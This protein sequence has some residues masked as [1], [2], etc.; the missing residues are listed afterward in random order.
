MWGAPP[1]QCQCPVEVENVSRTPES[2]ARSERQR[3]PPWLRVRFG[4]DRVSQETKALVRRHA[5]HTVCEEAA[6]PN[7]GECW[8]RR[9]A[10]V[11]ILGSVC[12]RACSFCNV[13]TGAPFAPDPDEPRRLAEAVLELGLRHVVITSVNRDDL[14]DGGAGQFARC[15]EEIHA[16]A[17]RVTV[18][19]LTPDFRRKEGAL[20]V[21]VDA[22]PDVFNHNLET[23]P[24][25]YRAVRPGAD[26]AH[27]VRLLQRVKEL[28]PGA[29][30]KSGIMLGLGEEHREVL[31]LMDDLR[32]ADV[33]FLTMGQ[34]LRPTPRHRMVDRY[35][36][37]AEFDDYREHAEAK[38]FLLVSSTPL[39]RSSY[40]A[41]ADFERLRRARSGTVS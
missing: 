32:A 11:M 5:L 39:T 13:E 1:L 21:V 30:T 40:H 35:V 14:L 6:C 22:R 16:R 36:P 9:H 20:E 38:G 37:P 27:S 41:D 3:K 34:Y 12:T 15:V 33:D 24:R 25:L 8:S 7:L 26:Y 2:D 18:E 29:F 31:A 4:S 10:T 23:V 28:E 17:P 19:V